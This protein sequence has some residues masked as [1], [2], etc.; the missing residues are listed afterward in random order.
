MEETPILTPEEGEA[1]PTPEGTKGETTPKKT[2]T[3]AEE[4]PSEVDYLKKKFSDSAREVQ[5]ILE[6]SK[7]DK[8]RIAEL[9]VKL[10]EKASEISPEEFPDWDL[11][12]ESEKWMAKEILRLKEKTKWE[13][14]LQKVKAAFPKLANKEGAFK[15]YCYKYPKSVDIEILAKSFLF[16]EPA[17]EL[18]PKPKKGLEKPTGGLGKVPSAEMTVEDVKRLRET[19]GRTYLKM[20]RDGTL[21]VPEK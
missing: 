21:K 6:S 4:L 17:E 1:I 3:P 5:R 16:E 12:S 14:D 18:E 20:I 8:T 11:M 15:E 9:E 13:E 7:L 10:A 19:D 2:T